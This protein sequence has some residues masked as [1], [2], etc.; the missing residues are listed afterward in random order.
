VA[1]GSAC[2]FF[3]TVAG[4]CGAVT[5]G[6]CMPYFSNSLC[7]GKPLSASICVAMGRVGTTRCLWVGV[8][9]LGIVTAVATSLVEISLVVLDC[10]IS[11]VISV[12]V[13]IGLGDSLCRRCKTS[14]IDVSTG[15]V[16][17]R[18]SSGGGATFGL[19]GVVADLL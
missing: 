8:I 7:L 3:D 14:A 6:V 4:A 16:G 15:E 13:A 9:T 11:S 1:I 2:I 19:E 18:S 10:T 5:G 12:C 17:L